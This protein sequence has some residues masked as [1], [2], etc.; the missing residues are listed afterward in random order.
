MKPIPR[1]GIAIFCCGLIPALILSLCL[2]CRENAEVPDFGGARAFDHLLAQTELGPR[3]PESEGWR[4]FQ[5]MLGG[6]LDSL[7]ISYERQPFE[8]YDYLKGETLSMVNWIAHI[9]PD[10]DDRILIGAHYDCRPRADYDP[11]TTRRNEPIIGANDGASG[12]AV[13]MH[14]AELMKQNPPEVGVDLVFF[15][16]EDYGPVGRNDQYMIGSTYFASNYRTDYRFGLIID[17]I[18]DRDLRIYRETLSEKYAP[19]INDKIWNTAA[20]LRVTQFV[21]S[22]KHNILDD[23]IPLLGA[24]IPTVD[25]IDFEYPPWHT[26]ADTP[27]KCDTASLSAVGRVVMEVIYAE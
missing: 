6:F 5:Q 14:M 19:E 7:D 12:V 8:Y 4:K 2:S 21:D 9:N 26:H 23:H 11:D 15:D 18:G 16:G 27:D 24:G 10:Q 3:N 22:V 25:I 20:R 1:S 17:M 13:L